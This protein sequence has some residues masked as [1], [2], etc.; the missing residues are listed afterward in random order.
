MSRQN[1]GQTNGNTFD[2]RAWVYAMHSVCD[3]NEV[4]VVNVCGHYMR[5]LISNV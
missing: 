4:Y 1:C 5:V 3:V 2:I